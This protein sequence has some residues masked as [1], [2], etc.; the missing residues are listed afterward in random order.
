MSMWLNGEFEDHV[1]RFLESSAEPT[2]WFQHNA[3]NYEVFSLVAENV[4]QAV[5]EPIVAQ[6]PT[7]RD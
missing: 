5:N 2:A 1:K 4:V 7:A 3:C 6:L